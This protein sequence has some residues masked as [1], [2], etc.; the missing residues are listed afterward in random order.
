MI[1]F[2]AIPVVLAVGFYHYYSAVKPIATAPSF[3]APVATPVMPDEDIP[4]TP[5]EKA[6][7]LARVRK[8]GVHPA[9][10]HLLQQ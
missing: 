10:L 8:F 5:D 6:A 4:L 2:L 9:D 7:I 1:P 3:P